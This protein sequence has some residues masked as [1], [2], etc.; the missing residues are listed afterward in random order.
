MGF[1][2]ERRG[3]SDQAF[4]KDLEQFVYLRQ[5]IASSFVPTEGP[6]INSPFM[7]RW[8]PF[9]SDV[10]LGAVGGNRLEAVVLLLAEQ[11]PKLEAIAAIT[12]HSVIGR[13]MPQKA[14]TAMKAMA[15]P[16]AII[17][18]REVNID[19]K[20]DLGTAVHS[21]C[22]AFFASGRPAAKV[23]KSEFSSAALDTTTLMQKLQLTPLEAKFAI[24]LAEK[25]STEAEIAYRDHPARRDLRPVVL[26]TIF[27]AATRS[28]QA[29]EAIYEKRRKAERDAQ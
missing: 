28:A 18:L 5:M 1:N 27:A 2:G 23:Q 20:G 8:F 14:Y 26:P 9:E 25:F 7:I 24:D 15:R 22:Q 17:L 11:R 6:V 19:L 3:L 10:G 12:A 29:L 13:P 16:V 21:L 4:R